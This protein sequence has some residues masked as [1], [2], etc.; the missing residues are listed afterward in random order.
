MPAMQQDNYHVNLDIFPLAPRFSGQRMGG[1]APPGYFQL[2][3][4]TARDL[5]YPDEHTD[6]SRT[7]VLFTA[8]WLRAGREMLPEFVAYH[9]M[10]APAAQGTNWG[11]RVTPRWGHEPFH[12][13]H[14]PRNHR[15]PPSHGDHHHPDGHWHH[16][17]HDHDHDHHDHHPHPYGP[18]P[19]QDQ[20]DDG[21]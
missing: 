17:G 5:Q 4:A 7:D 1:Y 8:N 12:N 19:C 18:G 21:E 6:A 16:H 15:E 13:R 14:H 2:W 20:T 9:L 3:N 11:G 10:A